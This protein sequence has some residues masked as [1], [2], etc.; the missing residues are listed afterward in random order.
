LALP[1]AGVLLTLGIVLGRNASPAAER[2]AAVDEAIAEI[3]AIQ[4]SVEQQ[5]LLAIA[6]GIRANYLVEASDLDAAHE[7]GEAAR[8]IAER[9]GDRETLLD[10][11]L[12]SAR[13]AVAAGRFRE[14]LPEGLAL[15]RA[16]RDEGFEGVGVT[17][18]RNMAMLA[19]QLMDYDVARIAIGE[20]LRY[21]DEIEQTHCRQMMAATSALMSWAAGAWDEADALAR[22]ELVDHGCRRGVIGSLEVMG[23]VAMGRGDV[24]AASR[25][26]DESLASGR[27]TTEVQAILPS[28]WVRAELDLVTGNP[29]A[30]AERSR[31]ALDL[32]VA[33]RHRVLL[34]PF[35]VTGTRAWIAAHRPDEAEHWLDAVRAA[36]GGW[37]AVAGPALAHADGLVRLATGSVTAAREGFDV[38]LQGWERLGRTWEASWAR[39]DLANALMRANRFGEAGPLLAQVRELAERLGSAPLLARVEELGRAGRGR[40]A[41]EEPWRPL[42]ARE[43]EVAGLVTAGMTNAEIAAELTIS[44]KTASAHVEHILAKLGVMRRAEIAAWTASIGRAVAPAAAPA[45]GPAAIPV[46]GTEPS[47]A[48]GATR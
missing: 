23:L 35:V 14:G 13:V 8:R 36:L 32:C 39:L 24:E 3:E 46:P 42:S 2:L 38:A 30:A 41:I 18:Y 43:F 21:A 10:L 34:V 20:G 22:Q 40:T 5:T 4:G 11:G 37:E 15:S 27:G 29:L 6:L 7:A 25:W 33:T 31:E 9:V 17:G 26:L 47:S 45:T 44:P 28:L 1:A 12:T 48:V 19:A 16:A